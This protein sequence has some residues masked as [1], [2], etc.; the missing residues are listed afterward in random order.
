MAECVRQRGGEREWEKGEK[1]ESERERE[2]EREKE[3]RVSKGETQRSSE[4]TAN[5]LTQTVGAMDDHFCQLR[6]PDRDTPESCSQLCIDKAALLRWLPCLCKH[7]IVC[8]LECVCVFVCVW[9]C[10]RVCLYVYAFVCVCVC[11]CVCVWEKEGVRETTNK[12]TNK[13]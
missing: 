9:E 5:L 4:P 7:Q 8:T 2:R 11:V 13:H 10:V 12:Q 1:K 6:S 3:R